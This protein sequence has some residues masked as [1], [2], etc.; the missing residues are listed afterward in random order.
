MANEAPI[1]NPGVVGLA[2]IGITTMLLQFHN[3]GWCDF[4]LSFRWPLFLAGWR[5]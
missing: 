1:G 4:A 2:G 5:K 3:V